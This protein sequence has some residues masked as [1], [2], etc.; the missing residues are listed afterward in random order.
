[1]Y[2]LL[3]YYGYTSVEDPSGRR[4]AQR[5]LCESLGILGRIY[6]AKEGVNGTCAGS[7][8]AIRAYRERTHEMFGPGVVDFKEEE[9]DHVPFADLRVKVRPWL[10][11]LG[12]GNNVLPEEDGGKR[13]TPSEWKAFMESGRKF[14]ML[15]VRNDYEAKIGHFRGAIAAPYKNFHEFPQW[16]DELDLDPDE[17]V[18]MYCTGGIRCEKFSGLLTR[19]GHR[20]VYQL[21]GGILRY[22]EEV[23]GDHFLGNVFVFDD[24]MSV[25]IGG[26][27]TPGRCVHCGA[28]SARVINC[29]NVDCH[30]LHVTCDTCVRETRATCSPSC[31]SAPRLRELKDVH[32][33]RPWRRLATEDV[34]DTADDRAGEESAE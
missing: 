30:T 3:S 23:G 1:M 22:A 12:E 13:L 7:A 28:P 10:V 26:E 20:E 19:K 25:D 2:R 34:T 9:V 24:R 16:V 33:T 32:L 4:D 15:D 5:E 14:T 8:D 21:D 31:L 27:P 11:N 6:V 29:A 18:L 17:P